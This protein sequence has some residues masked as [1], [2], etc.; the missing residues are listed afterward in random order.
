VP[1]VA[2]AFF[3]PLAF[4]PHGS[5]MGW[6]GVVAVNPNVAVTVPAMISG[7]PD[8][9]LVWRGWDD[10]DGAWWGRANPHDNLSIR[11]AN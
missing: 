10:F 8:P 11:S 7:D 3:A 6:V 4:N 9:A 5:V 1:D 2:A